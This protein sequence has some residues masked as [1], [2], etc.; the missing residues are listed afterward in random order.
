VGV[1]ATV[2]ALTLGVQ[3]STTNLAPEDAHPFD[4]EFSPLRQFQTYSH[5]GMLESAVEMF[6][7]EQGDY[8]IRL[9]Q[10]VEAGLLTQDD[11]TFPDYEQ[12]YY[13]R[14]VAEGYLLLPPTR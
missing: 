1:L 4:R 12:P 7:L 11:L 2:T 14:R 10:V 9:A 6:R 13:Y 5:V 3:A 8:P